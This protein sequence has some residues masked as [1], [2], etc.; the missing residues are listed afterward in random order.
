MQ[1][2]YA[3][4]I[5][6]V[7]V[8]S[9]VKARAE[10]LRADSVAR[11]EQSYLERMRRVEARKER[12]RQL[13]RSETERRRTRYLERKNRHDEEYGQKLREDEQKWEQLK[14]QVEAEAKSRS[15]QSRPENDAKQYWREMERLN[16][17]IRQENVQRINLLAE[18]RRR[19]VLEAH[20][21][22]DQKNARQAD[23][24][25]MKQCALRTQRIEERCARER[26][27]GLLRRVADVDPLKSESEKA[28]VARVIRALDSQFKLGLRL[29]VK[30]SG[31]GMPQKLGAFTP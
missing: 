17:M 23:T 28:R 18:H 14:S 22:M 4:S 16:A 24:T 5:R 8:V 15:Q 29:K 2:Q 13:L 11:L 31:T 6:T 26:T 27:Y 10:E 9:H 21:S 19:R 20:L 25:L 1:Q 7:V 30:T 12:R 3:P